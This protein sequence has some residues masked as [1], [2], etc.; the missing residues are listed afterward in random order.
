MSRIDQLI[1]EMCPRGVMESALSAVISLQRGK[2][3]TKGELVPDGRVPVVS[4]GQGFMGFTNESNREAN[5]IT[6]AQ[7]GAA[8]YLKWQDQAFWANDVCYSVMLLTDTL[9]YRFLYLL[10]KSKQDL[11]YSISNRVAVPYS[12]EA[13]RILSI[14][15]PVPPLEVQREI[16]SIL[17]KFTQLE[18]ELEAELEVRRTQY[19]VTRDRLLDFSSDL[20]AHP[21][22]EM[23]RRLDPWNSSSLKLEEAAEIRI[24]EFVKK[25]KQ[26]PDAS[27]PVY[28]G[29]TTETGF[30]KD[31]NSEAESIVISARGSIGFVNFLKTK[32]WAGNSCYVIR[33]RSEEFDVKYL[34][35]YLKACEPKLYRLRAVGGIPALNLG[36]V[37]NFPLQIPPLKVQQEIVAILDKLDTLVNDISIGLP[38]E[39]SA[40]RKQYEYYRNK[41]LTFKELDAA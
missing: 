29:G 4:G 20:D 38:A 3:I 28:N 32:F 15:I 31:F 19:E 37:R 30:Y 12:I 39:I 17:D 9:D 41:L 35:H 18:A 22:K 16:V 33:S 8:G 21:L 7:Y 6:I 23:I 2:R 10:L 1:R 27:Y 40:R 24:G 5:T 13:E 26:D 11:L 14:T 36:P 25:T 34:Y